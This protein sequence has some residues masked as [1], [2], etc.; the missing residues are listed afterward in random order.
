MI[1]YLNCVFTT[2]LRVALFLILHR[3]FFFCYSLGYSSSLMVYC[4]V[5]SFHKIPLLQKD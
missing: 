2:S 4:A 3:T 1:S 5:L